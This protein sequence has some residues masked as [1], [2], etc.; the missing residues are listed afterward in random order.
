VILTYGL[1]VGLIANAASFWFPFSNPLNEVMINE[2]ELSSWRY[3]L[4]MIPVQGGMIL[5][6]LAVMMFYFNLRFPKTY[7]WRHRA[8]RVR[9]RVVCRWG[10]PILGILGLCFLLARPPAV[11]V[12]LTAVLTSAIAGRWYTLNSKPVLALPKIVQQL[13]WQFLLLS[14][15]LSSL[16]MTIGKTGL[17]DY[18]QQWFTLL[19]GWGITLGVMGTGFSATLLSSFGHNLPTL[20]NNLIALQDPTSFNSRPIAEAMIYANL[21]GCVFGAKLSPIGSLSTLLWFDLIG[22]HVQQ[23]DWQQYVRIHLALVLP[24]LF[25]S[26]LAL[27]LWIPWLYP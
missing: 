27:T 8:R 7:R 23:L 11:F 16:G 13:P 4:V 3:L 22:R 21:I 5:L 24:V 17:T 18:L 20:V 10:F 25:F 15:C 6:S 1:G 9:D 14:L 19:S 26:L 12:F 2:L